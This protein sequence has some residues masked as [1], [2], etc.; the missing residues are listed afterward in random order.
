MAPGSA[1]TASGSQPQ[2]R[3][4][5][6]LS[7]YGQLQSELKA[8]LLESFT[9]LPPS[10]WDGSLYQ[11]PKELAAGQELPS[12]VRHALIAAG[13][14]FAVE[15]LPADL[16]TALLASRRTPHDLRNALLEASPRPSAGASTS[17]ASSSSSSSSSVGS[18]ASSSSRPPAHGSSSSSD[19]SEDVSARCSAWVDAFNKVCYA[20]D[21]LGLPLAMQPAL[22]LPRQH[23]FMDFVE[24]LGCPLLPAIMA[25]HRAYLQQVVQEWPLPGQQG[26]IN[27]KDYKAKQ[28][29]AQAGLQGA[30]LTA[31]WDSS[32]QAKHAPVEVDIPG[33]AGR[34][35]RGMRLLFGEH[36]QQ[37]PWL[38]RSGSAGLVMAGAAVSCNF[39]APGHTIDFQTFGEWLG[40]RAC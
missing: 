37:L 31:S 18:K 17:T 15:Q 24:Q 32:R 16:R 30:R 28:W 29:R 27:A 34:M 5:L 20:N 26:C 11:L 7:T 38:C 21:T 2:R 35:Q 25:R 13:C 23:T 6:L 8:G 3:Q 14:G 19:S 40:V 36:W 33:T 1:T 4:A 22:P 10:V 9:D 39:A 12:H